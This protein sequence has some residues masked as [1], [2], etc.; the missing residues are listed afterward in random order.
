MTEENYYQA[1]ACSEIST[2]KL[3]GEHRYDVC[4]VGGGV[5]GLSSAIHLAEKGYQVCV[6]E[7]QKIGHGASGRNGGQFIFGFGS[8]MPTVRKLVGESEAKKLWELS[9]EAIQVTHQL[10]KKHK[11][12]CDWQWGH[13]HTAVK[14]RQVNELSDFRDDLMR[15]YNYDLE[16]LEGNSLLEYVAS[17]RYLAGVKDQQSGHLHP[18]KYTLGLAK[19]AQ[20]MGVDL[21]EESPVQNWLGKDEVLLSLPNA[22]LKASYLVLAG[23]AYLG[24][25]GKKLSQRLMPVGTYMIAT[26]PL[27][28]TRAGQLLPDNSAV[29]D[30][31]FVLDYFRLSADQRL[32]FGGGVSY[33]TIPP[34]NVRSYLK[35]RMLKVFPSLDDVELEYGWGGLVGITMNRMPNFGRLA[36]NVYLAQ[37]FSGHGV[38]LTGLAG[39]LM[40]EVIS[41]TAERFDVMSRVPHLPFPGG[42]LFRMPALLLG[43]TWYRLRDLL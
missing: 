35:K 19:A 38:A 42:P 9:L 24:S 6:L 7:A 10:V 37:G 22:T 13:V 12:D 18:L 34:V 8:E 21:F 27:G 5:T 23:N 40:A 39:K 43:T 14:A 30:I 32:L 20:E 31:N 17:P 2:T 25:L 41:G 4:V 11:I 36:P 16:W 28:S 1:S 26:E 3:Q 15:H 29:A 33:S